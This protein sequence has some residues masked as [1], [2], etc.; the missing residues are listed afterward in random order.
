MRMLYPRKKRK[1][2]L[3][4]N[5]D[6]LMGIVW[7]CTGVGLGMYI[8]IQVGIGSSFILPVFLISLGCIQ[9]IKGIYLSSK[10]RK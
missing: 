6:W 10:N 7:I 1:S 3:Y 9:L 5:P 8:R 2:M 4:S